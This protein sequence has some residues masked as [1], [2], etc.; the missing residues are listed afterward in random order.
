MFAYIPVW[1]PLVLLLLV[2]WG[3]RQARTRDV[4]PG[5][6]VGVAVAMFGLSLFGV[7]ST[8][9]AVPAALANDD[10]TDY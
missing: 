2:V 9:G 5:L 6:L 10:W 3:L 8:F 4:R 1:V 7:V